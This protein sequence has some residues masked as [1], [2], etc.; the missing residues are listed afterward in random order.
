[1]KQ[2]NDNQLLK[3]TD[4]FQTYNGEQKHKYTTFLE[5]TRMLRSQ[6]KQ[7]AQKSKTGIRRER[8]NV[9]TGLLNNNYTR[10]IRDQQLH[11]G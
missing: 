11:R 10:V 8:D 5:P 9:S 3:K 1:M 2:D 4:C 6:G 7:L